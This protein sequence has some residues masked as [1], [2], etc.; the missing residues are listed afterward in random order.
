MNYYNVDYVKRSVWGG[1]IVPFDKKLCLENACGRL[2]G[3]AMAQLC[4]VVLF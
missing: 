1:L 4:P 2:Y 3:F